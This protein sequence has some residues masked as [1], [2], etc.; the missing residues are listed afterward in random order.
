MK[1]NKKFLLI[2]IICISIIVIELLIMLIIHISRE[3]N[4]DH[5][6]NLN[7]IIK[8][9]NGYI[10]VGISDFHN[11]KF[12]SEKKYE[13]IDDT[14][15]QK[16][17]IIATQ[18]KLAKYDHNYNLIWEKTFEN[19]YDSTFYDI[20]EVND[21]YIVVGSYAKDAKQ[22]SL[23][24]R[25]ALII[26]YDYNGNIVWK[27]TYSVLS[28]T[29]FY[30]V[31]EDDNKLIVIGQSIYENMELGNHI[32]GGG[33]IVKYDMNGKLLE[34]NNYGGNK[35]GKFNDIIK[36]DDGYIVCGK[37]ATNYGILVKFKKNFNRDEN[38]TSLISKKIV[39]QRTYS[40]T[41]YE[42]FTSIVQNK[43][44]LYLGGAINVS[45]EK[46]KEGKPTFKYD[47]GIVAYN[48]NSKYLGSYSIKDNVHHRINSMLI[49]NNYLYV[50]I[51][52][53]V[54]SKEPN[55]YSMLTKYNLKD[56]NKLN[57]N[58]VYSQT[59]VNDYSYII[60]KITKLDND[61]IYVGTTNKECK[62]FTGCDYQ[63]IIE[64]YQEN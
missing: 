29:E 5:I 10:G 56:I 4:I 41:D 64:K 8:T 55:K 12:V 63:N 47:A 26:K 39:W 24:T 7:T 9:N 60:N 15:K 1:K 13:Y 53:D 36:V 61:I 18:S 45:N 46:D 14:T 37:D 19:N 33:I 38:D 27:E 35:S 11:S 22:I 2:T 51:L 31:I 58:V 52:Y 48:T 17:N 44:T 42:G 54:D 59:F 57:D 32:T 34:K 3:R 43:D 6:D 25:D 30:K 28:D 40:N 62:F 23:N 49:D 50:S 16:Q 20:I 21:G